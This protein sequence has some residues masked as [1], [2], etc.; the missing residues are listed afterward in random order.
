MDPIARRL[1]LGWTTVLAAGALALVLGA[2][3]LATRASD[4]ALAPELALTTDV[5]AGALAADL[6]R[7]LAYGVPLREIPGVPD[8]L[9]D[10]VAANPVLVGVALSDAAG[11][12]VHDHRVP[13]ALRG[14]LAGRRGAGQDTVG[15]WQVS[16]VP[17]KTAAEAAP[18]GWLHVVGARR[19]A[20]STPLQV[21]L[22]AAAVAALLAALALRAVLWRRLVAPLRAV[23]EAFA[24]LADARLPA[25]D[26]PAIVTGR[27]APAERA[28]ALVAGRIDALLERN[29]QLLQKMGEV[30]AAHFDPAILARIDALAAPLAARRAGTADRTRAT[31]SERAGRGALAPR[32]LVATAGA[33]VV[34]A[35]AAACLV[36]LHGEPERRALVRSAEALVA[37]TWAGVLDGDRRTL[38]VAL[39]AA[40]ADPALARASTEGGGE[41]LAD[42]LTRLRPT[43]IGLSVLRPDGSVLATTAPRGSRPYPQR[44]ALERLRA[45]GDGMHGVWQGVDRSYQSGAARMA[46]GPR[47]EPRV[48]VATR[49]L[50]HAVDALAERLGGPAAIADLRGRTVFEEGATVVDAW[51]AAGRQGHVGTLG[52]APAVLAATPLLGTTGLTLGTLLAAP[53]REAAPTDREQLL[54]AIAWVVLIGAAI[55]ALLYLRRAL[56]PVAR[57]ADRLERLAT[58]DASAEPEATPALDPVRVQRALERLRDRI[59]TLGA[60]R[61]SRDRQGRR[62]ARFI[63]QQMLELASRLDERA[64]AN[65]LEDL[66]RIEQAGR[67]GSE[68]TTTTMASPGAPDADAADAGRA[69]AS[70]TDQVVDEIGILALGFQNLVG[71]VGDQYQELARYVEE[72]R[73]ALRVKT[74]FI[75]IQQEL[76]IARKMQLSFLPTAFDVHERLSLRATMN[77]AKEVGGDFYDFFPLDEHRV[78]VT[79]ADVSG[80]GV[81]AAFFMAVSRT[82]LRAVAR[83]GDGPAASLTRLNDLLAADNAEMMFVTL[84]YAVIDTRDGSVRYSNAGHNPPYLVRADGT[85]EALPPTGDVALAVMGGMDYSELALVLRPGDALAM[86]TDGVTEACNATEELFGEPRLESLLREVG[87]REV[88]EVTAQI[89]EAVKAFENGSPQTDDVTTLVVRLRAA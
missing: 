81:P 60:L 37:R 68:P 35:T 62:Q 50:R 87:G 1:W 28:L 59:E 89:V 63:R 29:R 45:S 74:Q 84:F 34:A 41:T 54:Q 25:P 40:A 48:L 39:D 23:R 4:R 69:A 76:E 46:T 85:I 9:G 36:A 14:A 26:G 6:Q 12:T 79:V 19:P 77:A 17:L 8:W 58:D 18:S 83:L 47:G 38:E 86:Y 20:G 7:A 66:R 51:R 78:A 22:A 64:R 16:T 10:I 88:A 15:R 5:I 30:R 80:K 52:D 42:A 53:P 73:E 3:T 75:A 49:P 13:E 55:A 33:I 24:G 57:A 65:V 67:P 61:R 31:A 32:M 11:A 82:L 70:R 71:R 21:S 44:I 27:K 43:G 56:V 72:L 2:S